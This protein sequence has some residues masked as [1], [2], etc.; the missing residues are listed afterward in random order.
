M[1][2]FTPNNRF[3]PSQAT[4][5][6]SQDDH[7]YSLQLKTVIG[8]TTSSP[9]SFDCHPDIQTFVL[10]AGSAVVLARVDAHLNITQKIFRARPNARPINETP[11][12]YNH[13]TPPATILRNRLASTSKDGG[14]G[15]GHSFEE[16]AAELPGTSQL[17]KRTREATCISLSSE[18][19]LLAVGEVSS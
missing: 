3:H 7:D 15:A 2:A 18:G 19:T 1:S 5:R 12:F 16:S 14:Y 8:T 6:P 9:N 11:T 13:S 4:G 17:S 10:C